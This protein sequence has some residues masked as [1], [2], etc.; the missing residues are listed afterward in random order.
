M[1]GGMAGGTDGAVGYRHAVSG[2]SL[3]S[4]LESSPYLAAI[5]GKVSGL[6]GR[7]QAVAVYCR[8]SPIPLS[9]S[10]C[11]RASWRSVPGAQSPVSS[12]S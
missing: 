2:T 3:Q 9:A 5:V 6:L 10:S 8:V 11:I 4:S 7:A 1:V 12:V